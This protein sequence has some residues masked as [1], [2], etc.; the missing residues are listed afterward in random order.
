MYGNFHFRRFG[1]NKIGGGFDLS[2]I[3]AVWNKAQVVFRYDPNKL[4]KDRCGAW[5]RG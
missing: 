2:I 5:T 4:R 3:N 1:T